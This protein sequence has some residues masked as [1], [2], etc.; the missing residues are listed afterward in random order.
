[1]VGEAPSSDG[2]PLRL[3][4]LGPPAVRGR[5]RT[6]TLPLTRPTEVLAALVAAPRRGVSSER[7]LD[8]LWGRSADRRGLDVL[9]N[10]VYQLN[11]LVQAEFGVRPIVA[12]DDGYRIDDAVDTD[13]ESFE[14]VARRLDRRATDI[15]PDDVFRRSWRAD[16]MWRGPRAFA[17]VDGSPLVSDRASALARRRSSVTRH[18]FTAGLEAGRHLEVVDD[19]RAAIEAEPYDEALAALLMTAMARCGRRREAIEV[20]DG[21]R[22]RLLDDAGLD[23]SA[24]LRAHQLRLLEGTPPQPGSP[25]PSGG[26]TPSARAELAL[27]AAAAGGRTVRLDHLAAV[28]GHSPDAVAAWLDESA[29]RPIVAESG[30]VLGHYRFRSADDH[31]RW[32]EA[33]GPTL[34]ARLHRRWAAVRVG[35]LDD[36]PGGAARHLVD[37]WPLMAGPDALEGIRAGAADAIDRFAVHEAVHLLNKAIDTAT[38]HGAGTEAIAPLRVDLVRT[39]ALLDAAEPPDD[40]TTDRTAHRIPARAVAEAVAAMRQGRFADAADAVEAPATTASHRSR[41][42]AGGVDV[43]LQWRLLLIRSTLLRLEGRFEEADAV[44]ADAHDLGRRLD[45]TAAATAHALQVHDSLRWAGSLDA[46]ATVLGPPEGADGPP[47]PRLLLAQSLLAGGRG[48]EATTIWRQ[49]RGRLVH[50]GADHDVEHIVVAK[51]LAAELLT[52]GIDDP[53]SA[54]VLLDDLGRWSGQWIVVGDGVACWGPVDGHRAALAAHLGCIDDATHALGRA[55]RQC[56][57]APAPLWASR[58]RPLRTRLA[59]HNGD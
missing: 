2:P 51:A 34:A 46:M 8:Q 52:S 5:G 4:L 58:L 37:A 50:P 48:R 25:A 45:P 14:A 44:S 33:T 24:E 31:R 16:A 10:A 56:A 47:L 28:V 11:R 27:K 29:V 7:L 9:K 13:V 53:D 21:F 39:T 22:R 43:D 15:D 30:H 12:S 1:M 18:R 57:T 38:R 20:Y 32:C 41:L 55:E 36:D 19:L 23:P 54:A 35:E 3:L 42:G 6:A 17:G 40:E 59:R 49:L 26:T